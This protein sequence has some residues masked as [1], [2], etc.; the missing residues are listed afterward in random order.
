MIV[1]LEKQANPV[2]LTVKAPPSKSYTHRALLAAALA[3][4][5]SLIEDP[6]VAEDTLLTLKALKSL[7][8]ACEERK[9]GVWIEGTG[10]ELRPGGRVVLDMKNSGTSMRLLASVALLAD[11]PVVLTGSKRMCKR[12]I[13]ALVSALNSIG[14]EVTCLGELGYP[15]IEVSGT[16]RGGDVTISS[17]ESSQFVTSLLL[18]APY[19]EDDISVTLDGEL[20]SESYLAITRSLMASFGVSSSAPDNRTFEV[21]AGQ[22]YQGR[23]YR[24]EGDYSSSSYFFAIGAV[25][26]GEVRVSNLNP[27]SPQGDRQFPFLLRDMGCSL[28]PFNDGYQISRHDRLAGIDCTMTAMPDTVQTLAAV[29]PFAEGETIIRGI[30][31]LRY[32]ESDRI[33]ALQR[34]LGT[35]GVQAPVSGD[36]IRIMPGN[37]HGGVIDPEDDHRTAMSGAVLGLGIGGVSIRD[38]EC[39]GKSFPDFWGILRGAGLW[40]GTS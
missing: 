16:L 12:P 25:C 20:V 21:A 11:Q 28:Q 18:A 6:L 30:A 39:V 4:G 35:V 7:G 26:G 24:V 14:G 23:I 9:E 5:E 1:T 15:P 32:K 38:A 19:A 22:A 37:L 10:G 33:L 40:S 27:D 34:V 17:A 13:G 8:V 29:A 31:H 2:H 36:A 3:E